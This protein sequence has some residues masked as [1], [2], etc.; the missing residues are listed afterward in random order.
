[1]KKGGIIIFGDNYGVPTLLKYIKIEDISAVVCAINRPKFHED[2]KNICADKIKLLI[3]PL[4]SSKEYKLFI[5]IVKELAPKLILVNSYSMKLSGE[6]IKIPI[7][8]CVNI[9]GGPL[10]EYR[11]CNP[12]QWAIINNDNYAGVTLHLMDKNLDTGPIIDKKIVNLYFEDSWIDLRDRIHKETNL[13]IEKN[14]KSLIQGKFLSLPQNEKIANYYP[15]RKIEDG[16]FEWEQP[17][18]KIYNIV[19]RHSYIF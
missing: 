2:I 17:L 14:I 19:S 7:Y 15:R 16:F 6:L 10:P 1:M 11:G 13:L 4:P 8:G 18:I 9:H 5:N 3:Q 12:M